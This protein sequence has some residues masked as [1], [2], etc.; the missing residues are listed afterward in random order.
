MQQKPYV[1]FFLV[2]IHEI[3]QTDIQLDVSQ[4]FKGIETNFGNRVSLADRWIV[5]NRENLDDSHDLCN[6]FTS[7]HHRVAA[8]ISLN[9]V[10][11]FIITFESIRDRSVCT[12]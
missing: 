10:I 12:R 6:L 9:F 8:P 11:C 1:I 5:Y 7:T 3:E 2:F 4:I